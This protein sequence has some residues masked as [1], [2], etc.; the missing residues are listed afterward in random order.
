MT[1]TCPRPSDHRI[2]LSPHRL[3]V[4]L[5]RQVAVFRQVL[6]RV[7]RRASIALVSAVDSLAAVKVAGTDVDGPLKP[8]CC[9]PPCSPSWP[10]LGDF[11][12]RP[13]RLIEPC[14]GLSTTAYSALFA[15]SSVVLNCLGAFTP[16]APPLEPFPFPF[17]DDGQVVLRAIWAWGALP[18]VDILAVL[19]TAD[20]LQPFHPKQAGAHDHDANVLTRVARL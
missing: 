12:G 9:C 5:P 19:A 6:R 7:E 3:H 10:S 20:E 13:P 2:P 1:V 11:P 17:V 16:P 8:C 15:A 4:D 18:P 14:S